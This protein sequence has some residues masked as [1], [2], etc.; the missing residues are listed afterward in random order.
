MNQQWQLIVASFH[1]DSRIQ[2]KSKS[3]SRSWSK[4]VNV[5]GMLSFIKNKQKNPPKPKPTKNNLYIFENTRTYFDKSSFKFWL[6]CLVPFSVST[7]VQRLV[8]IQVFCIALINLTSWDLLCVSIFLFHLLFKFLTCLMLRDITES[9][10]VISQ[11]YCWTVYYAVYWWELS[12]RNKRAK[13]NRSTKKPP[14]LTGMALH[15]ENHFIAFHSFVKL[16]FYFFMLF[17]QLVT[18]LLTSLPFAFKEAVAFS[19]IGLCKTSWLLL[20]QSFNLV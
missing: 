18:K 7:L 19:C 4:Q 17:S 3:Q 8:W 13:N 14:G 16:S 12:L 5:I 9:S 2:R 15:D 1:L 20:M 11:I 6:F 10:L